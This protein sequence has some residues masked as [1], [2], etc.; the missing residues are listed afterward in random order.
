MTH[1]AHQH[2]AQSYTS[3]A[4]R[5]HM[6]CMSTGLRN[7]VHTHIKV[8]QFL[9]CP[10]PSNLLSP[11]NTHLTPVASKV[12]TCS[13]ACCGQQADH[14]AA[15]IQSPTYPHRT[16]PLDCSATLAGPRPVLLTSRLRRRRNHVVHAPQVSMMQASAMCRTAQ[17]PDRL[18]QGWARGALNPILCARSCAVPTRNQR[19]AQECAARDNVHAVLVAHAMNARCCQP[20]KLA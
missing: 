19:T 2:M 4:T 10:A 9:S 5:L 6:T 1:A 11:Q 8:G 7:S 12:S 15:T 18:F 3:R 20:H 13:Q 16:S 14:T 17:V